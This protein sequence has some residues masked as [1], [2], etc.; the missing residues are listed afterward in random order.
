VRLPAPAKINLGL[1]VTG[2]R[3]DGYHLL[4]SVFLP[5]ELGDVVDLD[6]GPEPGPVEFALEGEATPDVPRDAHNLALRAAHVF[7]SEAEHQ[8][9]ARVG[10]V[11]IALEKWIPSEAGLGG[12]SSDAGAVLRGLSAL[13]PGSVAPAGLARL[14]LSLGADVPFFLDPRP[15]LVTGIG[16]QIEPLDGIGSFPLVLARRGPSLSTGQVFARFRQPGGASLTPEGA[17]PTIRP[18]WAL[19]EPGGLVRAGSRLRDLVHNDLEPA[20][21]S[22]NPAVPEL[23][24]EFENSGALASAMTGSGPTIYGLFAEEADAE[25]AARRLRER[26]GTTVW[27]TR[28]I[29]SP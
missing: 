22:L 20:A 18:L 26:D 27:R 12:G 24:R 17:D 6:L 5:L 21:T 15:A 29:P 4:E 10:A 7:L 8:G 1:R 11:R 19:R 23:Q 16:E 13:L 2:R 25:E 14:A 3:P 9:A 28:T